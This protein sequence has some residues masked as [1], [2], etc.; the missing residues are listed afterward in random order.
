MEQ[1]VM[2]QSQMNG[3]RAEARPTGSDGARFHAPI[4]RDR[5]DGVRGVDEPGEC[6]ALRGV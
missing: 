4:L 2:A 1:G 5:K 3:G 6:V